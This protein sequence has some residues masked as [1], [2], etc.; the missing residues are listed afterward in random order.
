ME[1]NDPKPSDQLP[2]ENPA[3]MVPDEQSDRGSHRSGDGQ[4]R[5]PDSDDRPQRQATGNPDNAG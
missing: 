1:H 2:E 3:E 4:D 5:E